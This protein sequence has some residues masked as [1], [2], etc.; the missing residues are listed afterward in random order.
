M[1]AIGIA[2]GGVDDVAVVLATEHEG[3]VVG[4][5]P[6]QQGYLGKHKVVVGILERSRGLLLAVISLFHAVLHGDVAIG[7]VAGEG[8]ATHA[9]GI[10]GIGG[11][12]GE[13]VL[14]HGFVGSG[15]VKVAHTLD[16]GVADGCR[17]MVAY[18]GSGVAIPAGKDGEPG[19][20]TVLIDERLHHVAAQRG[21]QQ[22]DEGV[23]G[24][25]GVPQRET[26]VVGG[27]AGAQAIAAGK[28]GVASIYVVDGVGKER[29]AVHG[30]VELAFGCS[31]AC[32]DGDA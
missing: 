32:I 30:A 26:I 29:G 12:S 17:G 28:A 22:G 10:L 25:V 8:A 19:A 18:H 31:V 27:G 20:L 1:A 5:V 21:V 11:G 9:V 23:L 16:I 13:G 14:A 15:D 4:R 6:K 7:E 3:V 24:T 2:C